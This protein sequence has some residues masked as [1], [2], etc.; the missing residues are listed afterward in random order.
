MM[1][2]LCS[3]FIVFVKLRSSERIVITLKPTE[4]INA[5]MQWGHPFEGEKSVKTAFIQ[6]LIIHLIRF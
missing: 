5:H 1:T 3:C 6:V 2:E 4:K